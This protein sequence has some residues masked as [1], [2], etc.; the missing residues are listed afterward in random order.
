[1]MSVWLPTRVRPPPPGVPRLMVTYSRITLWSPISSRVG[2]PL[3]FR[4]C[5]SIP[6][7]AKGKIRLWSPMRVGPPITTCE[8]SS[9][10]SPISTPAPTVQYGPMRQ[11]A[12]IL[13]AG[14]TIAVGWIMALGAAAACFTGAMLRR[15]GCAGLAAGGGVSRRRPVHQHAGHD[16]LAGEFVPD[17]GLA[18]HAHRGGAPGQHFDFDAQLVSRHHR[19]AEPGAFDAG[20]EHQLIVAPRHLGEQQRASGLGDGLHNQHSGHDGIAGEMSGEKRLI[21]ADVLDGDNAVFARDLDHA[22]D[23]QERVTVRQNGLDLI[24]VQRGPAVGGRRFRCR[25]YGLC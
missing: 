7:A 12:G 17:V 4:S 3:Y 18:A 11:D 8:T 15:S 2:S 20:E 14:S 1:M 23:Q 13:A 19:L 6:I 10:S 16:G 24:D 22:V 5:G 9:Q 25:M 21:D